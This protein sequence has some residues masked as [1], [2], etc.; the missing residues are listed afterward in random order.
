MNHKQGQVLAVNAMLI[1]PVATLLSIQAG[2]V[3]ERGQLLGSF[4]RGGSSV[5]LFFDRKCLGCVKAVSRKCL[6]S[7]L[8]KFSRSLL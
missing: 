5:A 4:A 8:G 2:S 3:V 7:S 6:G 1:L